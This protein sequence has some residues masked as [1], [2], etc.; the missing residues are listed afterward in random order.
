MFSLFSNKIDTNRPIKIALLG[1]SSTGK[2]SLFQRIVS[3]NDPNYRFSKEYK[4]TPQYNLKKIT[5]TTN[6]GDV[7]VHLWDTAGQ[8]DREDLR[9]CY[10]LNSDAIMI[11]YDVEE[12]ATMNNVRKW[13]S[14][15][16]QSC[17]NIPVL[18]VGNKMD[19]IK[20]TSLLNTVRVRDADLK[21]MYNN[22]SNIHGKLLSVR[23]N[24]TTENNYFQDKEVSGGIIKCFEKLLSMYFNK[25]LTINGL[26]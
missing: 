9:S 1:D 25:S 21:R 13:I 6:F 11:L 23:K 5:F 14:D 7:N 18:V 19:R 2:T 24:T 15:T 20:Q 16:Q 8:E 10:I 26:K 17:G 4:A 22:S 12:K 3:Y